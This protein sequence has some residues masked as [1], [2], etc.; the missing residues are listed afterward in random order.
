VEAFE[1]FGDGGSTVTAVSRTAWRISGPCREGQKVMD[2]PVARGTR[3]VAFM[4]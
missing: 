1:E 2:A 4:A 3:I